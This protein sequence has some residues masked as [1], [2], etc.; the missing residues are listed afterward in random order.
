MYRCQ[1][2][3]LSPAIQYD[4]I[5]TMETVRQITH[6]RLTAPFFL[7]LFLIGITSFLVF[8]IT[9]SGS[10]KHDFETVLT[11]PV[12]NLA[13]GE[14][15]YET[16]G[17]TIPRNTYLTSF[18]ADMTGDSA[19]L[20]HADIFSRRHMNFYCP[21]YPAYLAAF[22]AELKEVNFPD[23][24]GIQVKRGTRLEL[25]IHFANGS[26]DPAHG[27]FQ[28]RIKGETKR[29][30]ITPVFLSI[31]DYCDNPTAGYLI[32]AGVSRHEYSMIRPFIMPAAARLIGWGGHLHTFGTSLSLLQN[33][34]EVSTL[35]LGKNPRSGND[36]TSV[37]LESRSFVETP[38]PFAK[39]DEINLMAAYEKPK[40]MFYPG[41]MAIGYLIFDFE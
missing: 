30:D 29:K 3:P 31:A 38:L 40:D 37:Y 27:E 25:S 33:N 32:P 6:S 19:T 35:T 4:T 28:L 12:K 21:K 13:P 16:R 18:N 41:A 24:Y 17:I 10:V 34:K 8:R 23:P 1:I 36:P 15:R 2:M 39:G 26:K 22:G 9:E 7:I 14:D 11:V 5:K 20:H